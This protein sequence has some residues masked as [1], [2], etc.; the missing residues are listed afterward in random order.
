MSSV[1][2]FNLSQTAVGVVVFLIAVLAEEQLYRID[3]QI[4]RGTCLV[5]KAALVFI[6]VFYVVAYYTLLY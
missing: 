3:Y 4:H 1:F 2:T 6:F 5:L